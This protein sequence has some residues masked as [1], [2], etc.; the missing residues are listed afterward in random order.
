MVRE[1][2]TGREPGARVWTFSSS[3]MYSMAVSTTIGN[4]V[5]EITT[6]EHVVNFRIRK[7]CP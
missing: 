5:I 7:P 2:W 3:L 4:M 6:F 1:G